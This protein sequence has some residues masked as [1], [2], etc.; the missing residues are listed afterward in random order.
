MAFTE[1]AKVKNVLTANTKWGKRRVCNVYTDNGEEAI[2]AEDLSAFSHIKAGQQIEVIRGVKGKLTILERSAPKPQEAP[3]NVN[4]KG[5]KPINKV[6][7]GNTLPT[8]TY[9]QPASNGSNTASNSEEDILDLPFLSDADKRNM[10][11]YIK[12]QSK[13]LKFCYDVICQDFPTLEEY[14][15]RGA[16]SLAISLLISANQARDKYMK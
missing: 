10:M 15:P 11:S 3:R 12:S 5:L 2:W 1:Y 4:G 9:S 8:Q 16:R 6:L 7:G 13:L 14:D